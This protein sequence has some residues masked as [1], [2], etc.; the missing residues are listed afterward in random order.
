MIVLTD[1]NIWNPNFAADVTNNFNLDV[2]F[3]NTWNMIR[4]LISTIIILSFAIEA[5]TALYK[6]IRYDRNAVRVIKL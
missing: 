5:A 6:A 3:A 4:R 1:Y 2:D